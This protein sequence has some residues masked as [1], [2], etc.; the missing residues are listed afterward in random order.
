MSPSHRAV[1]NIIDW[2]DVHKAVPADWP[3]LSEGWP[4][5]CPSQ[6][7]CYFSGWA[8]SSYRT[9]EDCALSYSPEPRRNLFNMQTS[10]ATPDWLNQKLW[11]WVSEVWVWTS[12]PHA[13]EA[14]WSLSTSCLM[15][16]AVKK[17][18]EGNSSLGVCWAWCQ[19]LLW[20]QNPRVLKSLIGNDLLLSLQDWEFR[21]SRH[22]G[23][24][25]RH[26]MWIVIKSNKT[27]V[28]IK[29]CCESKNASPAPLPLFMPEEKL[30]PLI[31]R[32][33]SQLVI[34]Q[35]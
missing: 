33:G 11:G 27:D 17:S 20:H 4:W 8:W 14:H 3:V 10:G 34:I 1:V 7:H 18:V 16:R 15:Q 29:W 6:P 12:P 19:D 9:P 5:L 25:V 28:G 26:L 21:I 24:A 32:N 30:P 23:P 13:S 2:C 31:K 22:E 35:R